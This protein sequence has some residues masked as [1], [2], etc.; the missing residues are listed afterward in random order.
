MKREKNNFLA[1]RNGDKKAVVSFKNIHHLSAQSVG[2]VRKELINL[3][4]T[5]NSEIVIDLSGIQM[6]DSLVFDVLNLLSRMARRY[7]SIIYLTRID[8]EL[9]EIIKL[10]QDYLVFDLK[11]LKEGKESKSAA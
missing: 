3:V 9:M 7:N 1:I 5:R 4:T 2:V 6:I 11:I 8:V 10:I